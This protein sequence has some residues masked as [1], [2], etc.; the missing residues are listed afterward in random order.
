MSLV[1]QDLGKASV[2]AGPKHFGNKPYLM[3]HD[4]SGLARET[5]VY[6]QQDHSLAS[7]CNPTI[8]S[9]PFVAITCRFIDIR[10]ENCHWF[11]FSGNQMK[12]SMLLVLEILEDTFY[13]LLRPAFFS[14]AICARI[15]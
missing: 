6:C 14:N 12:Y 15:W 3:V 7:K 9:I 1:D 5:F 2:S 4:I 8:G 13:D 11:N 10:T